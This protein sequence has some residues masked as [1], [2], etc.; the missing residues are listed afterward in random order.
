MTKPDPAQ[1]HNIES[2]ISREDFP[3]KEVIKSSRA[4]TLC[5][6]RTMVKVVYPDFDIAK[7]FAA[8][9]AK[10]VPKKWWS[11]FDSAAVE[12][13]PDFKTVLQNSGLAMGKE[14]FK[15]YTKT[16]QNFCREMRVTKESEPTQLD[17]V[18]YLGICAERGVKYGTLNIKFC[19]LNTL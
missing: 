15:S 18:K 17:V 10:H 6:L 4:D 9:G 11:T 14:T 3:N 8:A 2:Y 1:V 19:G 12:N 13:M 7:A 16:W 5:A